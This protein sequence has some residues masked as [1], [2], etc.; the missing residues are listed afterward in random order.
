MIS[1]VLLSDSVWMLRGGTRAG[2]AGERIRR[3]GTDRDGPI[4]QTLSLGP[5]GVQDRRAAGR[6]RFRIRFAAH[7]LG[8]FASSGGDHDRARSARGRRSR[9]DDLAATGDLA[10]GNHF[11]DIVF[12]TVARNG[13]GET[14]RVPLP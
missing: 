4:E 14:S 12:G 6:S 10:F 5:G 7:S 3:R 11:P 13:A 9:V 2:A 8:R 1:G